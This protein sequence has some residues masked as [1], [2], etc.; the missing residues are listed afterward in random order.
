M[1]SMLSLGVSFLV[2]FIVLGMMWTVGVYILDNVF[3][4]VGDR[5]YATTNGKSGTNT[6]ARGAAETACTQDSPNTA[7]AYWQDTW[8]CT[9]VVLEDNLKNI[10]IW[11]VPILALFASIKM[12]VNASNRGTD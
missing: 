8:F 3:N 5:A 1:S 9:Y 11:A 7:Q 4:E 10:I 12:L 2:F 6:L